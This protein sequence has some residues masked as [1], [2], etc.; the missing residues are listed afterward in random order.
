MDSFDQNGYGLSHYAAN[1]WVLGANLSLGISDLTDGA[2]ETIVAGEVR[3]NFKPWG[4]PANWRDPMLGINQS[5]EGFGGPYE[6][7][8]GALF[9][10]GDGS[11][12][13]ISQHINNNPTLLKAMST[14]S[15][16]E[17]VGE[18]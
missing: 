2:S 4:D 7:S 3:T 16:G 12:R 9:L 5:P 15:G 10:F 18:F 14:P 6:Q 17:R 1:G 13:F 11:V 8:Y